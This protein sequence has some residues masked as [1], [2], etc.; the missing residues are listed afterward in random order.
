MIAKLALNSSKQQKIIAGH[1]WVFPNAIQHIIGE[2]KTGDWVEIFDHEKN[3]IG[4]GFYNHNSLYRVRIIANQNLLNQFK[5]WQEIIKYRLEQALQLRHTLNLPNELHTSY[6]LCNSECDG[7]SGLIID[8]LHDV[9]VISSNAF[10]VEANRQTITDII[11]NMFKNHSLL[12]FGQAKALK[13][14]G[15]LTPYRD[16]PKSLT[17]TIKENGVLFEIHF[18]NIQKT[19]IY[20]DQRENHARLANLTKG[21]KVLDLYTYHG[22]FA[23]HAAKAGAL[24]VTAV[25]SSQAAIEHAIRNASLNHT[26]NIDWKVGDATEYLQQA[27]NY[28]V[29]ILDPPKLIPSKKHLNQA[30]NL[31]RFLHRQLFKVMKTGGI[32]MTCNCSSALSPQDFTNLVAQQANLEGR[33]IQIL[34]VFGPALCHPTMPIFPEGQYL[35]AVLL[36]VM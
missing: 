18:D 28:D 10:W 25:D 36:S 33:Q 26:N 34:G 11:Q 29:V 23:L 3:R 21:K 5:T 27:G 13:Q 15:W 1:P 19:G 22:G 31:Y 4:G 2:P 9:I 16:E 8:V 32:L 7:L 24:C 14:D 35:T 20:I 12:W 6:R 17:T 30:K